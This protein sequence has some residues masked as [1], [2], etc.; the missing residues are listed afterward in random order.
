MKRIIL[1]TVLIVFSLVSFAQSRI[2]SVSNG[3]AQIGKSKTVMSSF[4]KNKG[5]ELEDYSA[6]LF[7]YK[8]STGYGYHTLMLS[9]KK[10]KVSGIGWTEHLAYYNHILQE[11]N[12]ANFSEKGKYGPSLSFINNKTN[13]MI[14]V[15]VKSRTNE[16]MINIGTAN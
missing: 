11:I 7:S 2:L 13:K 3:I 8:L 5:F 1:T 15:M 4:L 10:L 16:I 9:Y 6:N 12:Q 14:T